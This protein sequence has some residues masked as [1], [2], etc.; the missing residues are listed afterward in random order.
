MQRVPEPTHE[1]VPELIHSFLKEE[2]LTPTQLAATLNVAET[3]VHRWLKGEARP[4]G[5][6]ASILWTL[7]GLSGV[8]LGAGT[9]G[10]I[11]GASLAA[12][13]L[14]GASVGAGALTSGVAIY[15]LLKKRIEKE[16][17]TEDLEKALEW[18]IEILREKEKQAQKVESLRQK[19][20]EEEEK[21]VEIERRLLDTSSQTIEAEPGAGASSHMIHPR[22]GAESSPSD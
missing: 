6:A 19:L 3:T 21:L 10:F 22:H 13:L 11:R 17:L 4:T 16:T 7:I 12:R 14:R 20:E 1:T 2:G 15:R 8:A 18:E 5:T 9:P